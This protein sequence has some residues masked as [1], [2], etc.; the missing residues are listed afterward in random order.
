MLLALEREHPRREQQRHEHQRDHHGDLD[1]EHV[2]RAS[3]PST[4]VC[5]TRTGFAIEARIGLETSRL[6]A[7]SRA[8]RETCC[9]RRARRGVAPGSAA[10]AASMIALRVAQAE[11]VDVPTDRQREL[12]AR[13]DQSR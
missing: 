1:A 6:S 8:K 4:T 11:D 3:E 5:L 9:E 2:E 13:D 10:I 12:A 7:A